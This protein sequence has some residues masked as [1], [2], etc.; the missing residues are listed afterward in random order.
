MTLRMEKNQPLNPTKI[1]V[2]AGRAPYFRTDNRKKM[3]LISNGT[4]ESYPPESGN[5]P[6][7]KPKYHSASNASQNGGTECKNVVTGVKVVSVR[8]PDHAPMHAPRKVPIT[9][10]TSVAAP[11]RSPDHGS[12]CP[13]SSET[14]VGNSL[15]DVPKRKL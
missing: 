4:E 5:H 6:R 2:M 10:E 7:T 3:L 14:G 8:L 9:H 1:N 13:T 11:T 15:N 12:A